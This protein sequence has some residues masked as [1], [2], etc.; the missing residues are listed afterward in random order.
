MKKRAIALILLLFGLTFSF[1]AT[2]QKEI[3]RIQVTAQAITTQPPGQPYVLDLSSHT[4]YELSAGIDLSR[5]RVRPSSANFSP[6]E[7]T[8]QIPKHYVIPGGG[9]GNSKPTIVAT[10]GYELTYKVVSYNPQT[11]GR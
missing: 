3:R 2:P 1:S 4:I 6:G 8:L 5:L 7:H 11:V 9:T 10:P